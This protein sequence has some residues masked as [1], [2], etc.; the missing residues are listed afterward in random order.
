MFEIN[1]LPNVKGEIAQEEKNWG[2]VTFVCGFVIASLA[3]ILLILALVIGMQGTM[4]A[5]RGTELICR[6]SG[7]TD[8]GETIDCSRY[9]T[10]VTKIEDLQGLMTV[11]RQNNIMSQLTKQ[12]KQSARVVGVIEAFLPNDDKIRTTYS[13]VGY[14]DSKGTIAI[15]GAIQAEDKVNY[16]GVETMKKQAKSIYFDYGSYM[17]KT[18]DGYEEIPSFCVDEKIVDG[19]VIGVY[20][21]GIRGCEQAFMEKTSDEEDGQGMAAIAAVVEDIEIRRTYKDR[22]ERDAAKNE[23]YYFDSKCLGFTASGAINEKT[24]VSKCPLIEE[25]GLKVGNSS[26]NK[27]ESGGTTLE[28]SVTVKLNKKVFD[29]AKK[30]MVAGREGRFVLLDGVK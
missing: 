16:Q 17:R 27:N 8:K 4:L 21:K 6:S 3:G 5:S 30:N 15:E 24:A 23:G 26:D 19:V 10:P 9:G 13:K 2:T 25:D 1:L 14:D 28:F 18:D 11:Q 22:K 29:Y 20:H 12:K 7:E